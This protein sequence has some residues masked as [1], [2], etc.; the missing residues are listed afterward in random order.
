MSDVRG[1]NFLDVLDNQAHLFF[2]L[3]GDENLLKKMALEG[4]RSRIFDVHLRFHLEN[5]SVRE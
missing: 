5:T 1:N 4:C 2:M 3:L